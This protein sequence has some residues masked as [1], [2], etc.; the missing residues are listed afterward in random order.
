M[1][2]I[3]FANRFFECFKGKIMH[4]G[5]RCK[6]NA[7]VLKLPDNIRNISI[8][9]RLILFFITVSCL[10]VIVTGIV[11]Y[12]YSKVAITRQASRSVGELV[13]GITR[14]VDKEFSQIE[15]ISLEIASNKYIKKV[16]QQDKPENE[17]EFLSRKNEIFMN[18]IQQ[19]VSNRRP[20][21]N[22]I[23][24]SSNGYAYSFGRIP[25]QA[26]EGF[27][28]FD[29]FKGAYKRQNKPYWVGTHV[30]EGDYNGN[31]Y[32]GILSIA[33]GVFENKPRQEF[34]GVVEIQLNERLLR[35]NFNEISKEKVGELLIVDENGKV[36]S[37]LQDELI[38][39][40]LEFKNKDRLF[41]KPKGAFITWINGVQSLVT[42]STMEKTMWKV[43]SIQPYKKL[44]ANSDKVRMFT[45]IICLV[46]A[47]LS[48]IISVLVSSSIVSP[49]NKIIYYM[50]KAES[51]NF[52]LRL[53]V[54]SSDEI[55][56]LA[57]KFNHMMDQINKLFSALVEEQKL[58]KEAELN[59]LQA[60][61]TPHFLY[62]TL[63]SIRCL[64][65]IN[66]EH[67]ISSMIKSLIELLQ[68]SVDRYEE[69]ITL[70]DELNLANNYIMLQ[71]I[72][73]NNLF[74]VEYQVDDELLEYKT[75]KFLLQPLIENAIIHGL[76]NMSS[77]GLIKICGYKS[78]DKLVL[79]VIDNGSGIAPEDIDRILAGD[80]KAKRSKFSGI[81]VKNVNDRIKL[82][83]GDEYGLYYESN[84]GKGTIAR[85]VVP[86][87]KG[88]YVKH[89]A[90]SHKAVDF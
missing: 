54:N 77:G 50:N 30:Y 21:N 3:Y 59:A 19:K 17:L 42:Y 40:T 22:V 33:R 80:V 55:G 39:T 12:S 74:Q 32:K 67:Q 23:L 63:N 64:A 52:G 5:I 70:H 38:G 71:K 41:S 9:K 37:T 16:L 66:K 45:F 35:E 24:Y 75:L 20:I 46:C 60:Q 83:F 44:I 34:L 6:V 58:K 61:I 7:S 1:A 36:I 81:G 73:S 88:D 27:F 76:G 57:N 13:L 69:F 15:V 78:G 26:T 68:N 29:I 79:E 2:L 31:R 49:I 43:I 47:A 53:A 90:A 56:Q 18:Y 11:S 51:G 82:F 72:R 87:F 28:N 8:K 84:K 62:N 10:P 65:E 48:I 86:L 89:E 85:I 14:N 4:K 25:D